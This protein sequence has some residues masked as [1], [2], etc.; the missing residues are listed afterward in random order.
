MKIL[1]MGATGN[2]ATQAIKALQVK[3]I[4]PTAAVLDIAKAKAHLGQDL[5]FV[6]FDYTKS[7]TF[8]PALEGVDRLFLIAPP[9]SKDPAIVREIMLVAKQ[10]GVGFILF[11]SGRTSG[12]IEGKPLNQIEKDLRSNDLNCCIIRPAWYMQNFHTWTGTTLEDDELCIPTG[13]DKWH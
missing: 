13:K 7:D 8:A 4:R 3:G 6:H 12:C 5:D 9:G 1:L 11:Q 2:A 10:K